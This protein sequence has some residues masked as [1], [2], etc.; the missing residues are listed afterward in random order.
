MVRLGHGTI[1]TMRPTLK[2]HH[3][4]KTDDLSLRPGERERDGTIPP[5]AHL[6]IP[7]Y[8]RD[9]MKDIAQE[10][11]DLAKYFDTLSKMCNEQELRLLKRQ[12]L[13]IQRTS[14]YLESLTPRRTRN[15]R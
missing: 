1:E 7:V 6:R 11:R 4:P 3:V 2:P 12:Y 15:D 14:K 10:L 13:A 5:Y 9:I 8:S